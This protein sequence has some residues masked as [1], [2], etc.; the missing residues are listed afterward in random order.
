[1]FDVTGLD[2]VAGVRTIYVG[3]HLPPGVLDRLSARGA[4][5]PRFGRVWAALEVRR[6]GRCA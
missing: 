1:M 5:H 4:V 6:G 3:T 2:V